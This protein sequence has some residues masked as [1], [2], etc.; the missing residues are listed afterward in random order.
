MMS[1]GLR[2]YWSSGDLGRRISSHVRMFP[3]ESLRN[4]ANQPKFRFSCRTHWFRDEA[5]IIVRLPVRKTEVGPCP[6][7]MF[8]LD[9]MNKNWSV[10]ERKRKSLAK[11]LGDDVVHWH[12]RIR[13]KVNDGDTYSYDPTIFCQNCNHRSAVRWNDRYICVNPACRNPLTGEVLSWQIN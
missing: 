7:V 3:L 8:R 9:W 12:T 11:T 6:V 1:D 10:I 4:S 5:P 2:L 13:V